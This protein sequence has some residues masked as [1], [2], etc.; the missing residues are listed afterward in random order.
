[1]NLSNHDTKII[2][3]KVDSCALFIENKLIKTFK[4]DS[5]FKDMDM[6]DSF[7]YNEIIY[8]IHLFNENS[9]RMYDDDENIVVCYDDE[10]QHWSTENK[11]NL[12]D[13]ISISIYEVTDIMVD[14]YAIGNS[15]II[16]NI[17]FLDL[18]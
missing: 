7:K 16:K 12:K 1:M 3:N 9:Q 6:W 2:F 17:D 4:L 10:K 13:G 18:D 15:L 11:L 14:K 8:D 5:T